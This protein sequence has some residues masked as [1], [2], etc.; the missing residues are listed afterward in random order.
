VHRVNIY[1]VKPGST[2]P[3]L[4]VIGTLVIDIDARWFALLDREM[5][6][7]DLHLT[8]DA[9]VIEIRNFWHAVV[10]DFAA[11]WYALGPERQYDYHQRVGFQALFRV[12]VSLICASINRWW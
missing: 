11:G 3:T 8:D 6:C 2:K 7:L 9:A 1:D 12:E 10:W 5:C 4:R